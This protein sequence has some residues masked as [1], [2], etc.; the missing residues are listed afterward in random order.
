MKRIIALLV[1][2]QLAAAAYVL[3]QSVGG[4]T[5]GVV[6]SATCGDASHALSWGGAGFGCQ[7]ITATASPGGTN[8]A[9]QYNSSGSLGGAVITG[10][11]KG[12]GTSAP[13]A[14][15]S[16]TD[17]APATSGSA[18]LKGNGSGGFSNAASGTDYAP[19]TS[20]SAL[21]KGNGAGGFSNAASGTDYAPATTGSS[22]LK[23]SGG[24]FANA[25]SGTDYAP[26]TSGSFLLKG[27]GSGGFNNAAA[28]TDYAAA[29]SGSNVLLGNGSGGFNQLSGNSLSA[30]NFASSI[31][32]AGVITGAQPS[33]S[34]LSDLPIPTGN[35]GTGTNFG[36]AG[37]FIQLANSGTGT[38]IHQWAISSGS[39]PQA[40]VATTA[41]TSG[42]LG[43]C[44]AGCG[45]TGTATIQQSGT[46]TCVFDGGVT[47]NDYVQL[48][49]TTG[50]DCHD[51]G[52]TQ[53][54]GSLTIGSIIDT[55]NASP[56][57]YK[58][59][60]GLPTDSV[61][62]GGGG[63]NTAL[64]IGDDTA[65]TGAKNAVSG[66]TASI[67]AGTG[68]T[69]SLYNAIATAT[70]CPSS[71]PCKV[72]LDPS[73]TY[74]LTNSGGTIALPSNIEIAGPGMGNATVF[75]Q[76]SA[77]LGAMFSATSQSYIFMH[78]FTVDCN[79]ANNATGA[80]DGFDVINSNHI[81]IERVQFQNCRAGASPLKA[82]VWFDFTSG[83]S[84]DNRVEGGIFTNDGATG[85]SAGKP[86]A[87]TVTNGNAI[88]VEENYNYIDDTAAS[89][90]AM[91]TL[92]T[93]SSSG[94]LVG[95][96][97]IG[98]YILM[99]ASSTWAI[100]NFANTG[101]GPVGGF[102][103]VIV[104]Y[105]TFNGGATASSSSG[106]SMAGSAGSYDIKV[107]GNTFYHINGTADENA[108]P[109]TLV[110]NNIF[111]DNNLGQL[112][113]TMSINA[114]GWNTALDCSGTSTT[115]ALTCYTHG[116]CPTTAST[117]DITVLDG[118]YKIMV[119][120]SGRGG[121][122]EA[123]FV[124][125]VGGAGSV[126]V[127]HALQTTVTCQ[128]IFADVR[129]ITVQNNKFENSGGCCDI[130]VTTVLNDGSL[131]RFYIGDNKFDDIP[132]GLTQNVVR[133]NPQ[134]AVNA[135]N[136]L[137]QNNEFFDNAASPT[138]ANAVGNILGK[139][140]V[141]R[142]NTAYEWGPGGGN[143]THAFTTS[144]SSSGIQLYGNT[145]PQQQMTGSCTNAGTGTGSVDGWV[146]RIECSDAPGV[147][148]DTSTNFC[149][150][151]TPEPITIQA[152]KIYVEQA[153]GSCSTKPTYDLV[154]GTTYN[155]VAT[156]IKSAGTASSET[157]IGVTDQAVTATTTGAGVAGGSF[158]WLKINTAASSCAAKNNLEI[159]YTAN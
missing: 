123:Y 4:G 15:T 57:T 101:G 142:N 59:Q 71:T 87:V 149:S 110:A 35:G 47:S 127:D 141:V 58:I 5:V 8:G 88:D 114:Q 52:A 112:T 6:P 49:T 131:D 137:I 94:S 93:P 26:A 73:Q 65:Y 145:C 42:V 103:D 37:T 121:L 9:V 22:I 134:A 31:S 30:H 116:N 128:Q 21:L 64:Q 60:V 157:A 32:A 151:F 139:N 147:L 50:G 126:T 54:G 69:T 132:N 18:I 115:T 68:T 83:T 56:G 10:L 150:F 122:D 1:L 11:I 99:G 104:A 90:G 70:G 95:L 7:A 82:A 19:A 55:S 39:P 44:I 38:T 109:D 86:I 81:R 152:Y 79:R 63:V 72:F 84:V 16:G 107:I 130:N 80:N 25:V 91:K 143:G 67:H 129:D 29:T 119:P 133:F 34:D 156:T 33:S 51:A 138:S 113:T 48:S 12:N 89:A 74:T 125:A 85:V 27:N 46:T 45:N 77:V 153:A 13:T 2:V 148:A 140:G 155:S 3:A 36:P 158:V 118:H 100:E 40:S 146:H 75:M 105:N 53:P 14:A 92:V 111:L 154:K 78:D 28:G 76:N 24:G 98:N 102:N 106:L 43:I 144:N 66:I 23:A 61:G 108:I 120:G 41:T 17:Y 20:G 96:R 117:G 136:F 124:T 135:Q 62:S 97:Q 159:Q